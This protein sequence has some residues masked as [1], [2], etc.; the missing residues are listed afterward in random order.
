MSAL[1]FGWIR[2]ALK[3]L[4]DER[5][6]AVGLAVLVL[7]TGFVFGIAPRALAALADRVLREEI[8]R[9]SL[10]ERNIQFVEEARIG[11][12]GI[13]EDPMIRVAERGQVL[14]EELPA[15]SR[16]LIAA[17]GY[18]VESGRHE[19]YDRVDGS[20][21]RFR[22]QE[23]IEARIRYVAGRP[24]GGATREVDGVIVDGA[25]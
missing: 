22:W 6:A 17:R 10:V 3:R 19:L 18:Q 12:G 14:D 1:R 21:I 20:Y 15:S 5:F 4:R 2:A 25:P 8:G 13:D 9:A 23:G 24:P 16:D 11:P 7:V